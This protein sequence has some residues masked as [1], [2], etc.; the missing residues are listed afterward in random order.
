MES[1][2]DTVDTDA[3]C[4]GIDRPCTLAGLRSTSGAFRQ[5]RVESAAKLAHSSA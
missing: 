2:M 5:E 3:D 4:G 1:T